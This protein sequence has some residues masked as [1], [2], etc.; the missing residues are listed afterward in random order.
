MFASRGNS[1][2]LGRRR[3]YGKFLYLCTKQV[4]ELKRT[5]DIQAN[6]PKVNLLNCHS[7]SR[8]LLSSFCL[9]PTILRNWMHNSLKE[10]GPCAAYRSIRNTYDVSR[11]TLARQFPSSEIWILP[12]LLVHPQSFFG[13]VSSARCQRSCWKK[14][15]ENKIER[16]LGCSLAFLS[17]VKF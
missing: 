14:K 17:L 3:S 4:Y 12:P 2:L 9:D 5:A 11:E 6:L 10:N 7:G 1:L 16:I 8:G 15:K 13:S